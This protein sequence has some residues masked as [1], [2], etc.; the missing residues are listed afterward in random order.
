MR[1]RQDKC[2]SQPGKKGAW[3]AD[4]VRGAMKC[5][6]QPGSVKRQKQTSMGGKRPGRGSSVGKGLSG[7]L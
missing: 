7:G 6:V 2:T 4:L 1:A 3:G 5:T